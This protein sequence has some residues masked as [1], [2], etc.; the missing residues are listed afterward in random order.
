[1]GAG[2]LLAALVVLGADAQVRGI[3]RDGAG[4]ETLSRV[5]IQLLPAGREAVTDA[6]GSFSLEG[7]EP[8]EYTLRCSTVGY[9]IVERRFHLQAGEVKEFEVILSPETLRPVETV[10]VRADPF[11][12]VRPE[13]PSELRLEGN[14][15]KNLASVLADDPLRAVQALPGVASN[16][17]ADSR[18]AL[19]GASF[20]RIG[21]YLDGVLLA[22]PFHMVAAE[23]ASGAL[24]AFQGDALETIALY[25]GAPPVRYEDRTA[26]ALDLLTREGSR[27]RPT[28]RATASAS[29]ASILAEGPLARRRGSWIVGVRK[30][31]LRYIIER[32]VKAEPTLA[33]G[34]V[35]AQGRLSFDAGRGHQVTLSVLDGVSDLD[36]TRARTRLGINSPMLADHR[37]T[38]AT[39]AWRWTTPRGLL[40]DNRAA[41][42]R[43][44]HENRNREDWALAGG[45]FGEWVWKGSGTWFWGDGRT[46]DFGA[47]LRR[48]RTDGFVNQ[49]QLSPLAL[50][51]LD[52][53][54]GRGLHAGGYLQQST[55]LAGGRLYL[56]AGLRWD[57]LGAAAGAVTASPQASLALALRPSTRLQLAWGQYAQFPELNWLYSP[58]GRADLA[59]ER[60]THYVAAF[61]QRLGERSRLRLEL[62]NRQDRDLLFRPWH[63]PR[64][65]AGRILPWRLDA[66]VENSLRGYARGFDLYLQRRT[67]NGLTGWLGYSLSYA[68][69][70]DGPSGA[71]FAADYDQR[72]AV[73]AY[74]GWRLRPSV[75]LSTR[76]IYGSGFPV[77]GFLRREGGRYWLAAERNRVRLA[78]YHRADFRLN[79]AFVLPRFKATLYA[80]VVNIF[81]RENYRFSSFDG[82]N[83]RTGQAFVSV[84]R[85]LPVLPSAGLVLEL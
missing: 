25:A 84:D 47:V 69:M 65:I 82:Y 33:F 49:Y 6:S 68:R 31:Y 22:S 85:M 20:E 75:H 51:R 12:P 2:A 18:F 28:L 58:L 48:R 56:A 72:H 9:R 26:A 38:L 60:A 23:Q 54:R 55:N 70:R 4:G 46:L 17:D 59:P 67:A 30:S 35:D 41:W 50:R 13:S 66:P 11:E 36:R 43:N 64:L 16:D 14:E 40:L 57:R 21:L 15:T 27:I 53:A 42:L 79:K 44:R 80:E 62:Y 83:A 63:E 78:P 3:V 29:N 8:G 1:M 61:E 73:N 32:T 74:L 34:F 76:W 10:E 5:R 45:A 7:I 39:V 37:F 81:N 24:T 19:R 52:E 71:R 77:P